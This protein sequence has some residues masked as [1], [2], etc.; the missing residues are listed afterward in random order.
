MD[1]LGPNTARSG[2]RPLAAPASISGQ[3]AAENQYSKLA[4]ASLVAILLFPMVNVIGLV[5]SLLTGHMALSEIKRSDGRLRGRPLALIGL[6]LS[7][8]VVTVIILF[9]ILILSL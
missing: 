3:A 9:I 4:I 6:G 7:Y 8:L 1:A 5:V 2:P